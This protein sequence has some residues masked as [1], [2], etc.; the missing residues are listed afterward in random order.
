MPNISKPAPRRP[1]ITNTAMSNKSHVVKPNASISPPSD[2][3][4]QA[5]SLDAEAQEEF[6][7]IA[8]LFTNSG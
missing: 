1:P 4:P 3:G 5:F 7:R 6:E 8:A 2:T